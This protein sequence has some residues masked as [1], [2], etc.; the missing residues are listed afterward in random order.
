MDVLTEGK[1]VRIITRYV[2][3]EEPKDYVTAVVKLITCIRIVQKVVK[4]TQTIKDLKRRG[5][6]N[7]KAFPQTD[8]SAVQLC[9]IIEKSIPEIGKTSI[10]KAT[11]NNTAIHVLLDTGSP[12]SFI[13]HRLITK[14][15]L[16]V[17]KAPK[18]S[19]KGVVSEES[20]NTTEA[21]EVPL[22]IDN[23]TF[24][25][26][27]YV[28]EYI[29]H[30]VIIGYPTLQRFPELFDSVSTDVP[31]Y[32]IIS[33]EEVPRTI[34]KDIYWVNTVINTSTNSSFEKLPHWLAEKYKDT[35]RDDL[36][37][38]DKNSNP[39]V[40]HEIELIS[41][42]KTPKSQP[43]RVTPKVEEEINKIVTDL[44]DKQ[45]IIS[46]KS[47]FSSPIVM[48]KKKDGTYRLCVDYRTLNKATVKDPFPLPRT[49]S[50]LAK[51]GAASIFTTLDLHSGYHQIPMKREDRYKTAFVTP[52]GK[53]EYTVMPFGLVNA[54]STFSRY[55]AD[56]FREM[57][58]VNVYL[59][60]ILIFS[61]SETEH[62]KHIDLVLQ[63][64]KNEQLIV[65]KPK[66]S[67]A[68][69]EVEYLGYI[70]SEHKI[71]PV[72]SK[73]E[74]ISKF[75]TPNNVKAA[76]RFLGMINY[77]RRFIPHCSTIAKP[78]QDYINEESTWL[79]PQT[80][81]MNELKTILTNHPI[82]VPFQ[83]NGNYRLTT[84]ASKYGIGAVLEE[85]TPTGNVLGVVGYYSQSLK[86]AQQNYPAGELELLGIV[87]AL[88]HF[89]YLLHGIH[90]SLRTDHVSLLSLRNE[91]EP[92]P[93]VQRHL[94]KLADYDFELSYIPGPEN[95]VADALSRVGYNGDRPKEIVRSIAAIDGIVHI[96]PTTWFLDWCADPLAGAALEALGVN[97]DIDINSGDA[98]AFKKYRKKF[99]LSTKYSELFSFKND[100]LRYRE[101]VVVPKRRRFELLRVY[102]DHGIHGGHFGENVTFTKL[103]AEYFWPKMY[104][105]IKSHIK[106]CTHCQMMKAHRLKNQGLLTP[107]DV[108]KGR[109]ID[110]AMDF[111]TGLPPA[112]GGENMI[113]VVVDRFTKRAHFI[114]AQ[115]PLHSSDVLNLMFRY[116]FAYHGFPKTI[117]SDRD[118]RFTSNIYREFTERL[119]IKL[120]MSSSNHPQTDGQSERVIQI[121]NR[122]L[123]TYAFSDH[124]RWAW[125]LPQVEFVYNS[126]PNRTL[127]MSPFEADLG[128]V[129]NAPLLKTDG[130][131]DARHTGGVEWTRR[132]KAITMRIQDALT[133][134][135]AEMEVEQNRKRRPLIFEKGEFA[136][137]HRN[138]YFHA[139]K[140]KK[141]QPLFVGPF[142]VVK[143]IHDN[144]YELD[145]PT[146]VK[147]HRVINVHHLK[148]F[149]SRPDKYP[150]E[151]PIT[152]EEILERANEVTGLVG[153][154]EDKKTYYCTMEDVDPTISVPLTEEQYN[155]IP[156]WTRTSIWKNFKQLYLDEHPDEEGE[157]VVGK[158]GTK[159]SLSSATT[160]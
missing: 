26:Q 90:F 114:A 35:V 121:L 108:P 111:A 93:R 145:L 80:D 148:K 39:I 70:I 146:H 43:Y 125:L 136:L 150:K 91:T 118:V 107:L 54:P 102:H 7:T 105:D 24:T 66:C 99:K 11:T 72:Q 37:A 158:D 49:E 69:K 30:D 135:Q 3:K 16:E 101:Q 45:F 142:K 104:H 64:L 143:K 116:I 67:F 36:P 57:K 97:A 129:P 96:D 68:E 94:D 144:A 20:A 23:K 160:V 50:A 151:A 128:Y 33:T 40:F 38:R 58:F 159:A 55:M 119:G 79:Q 29:G 47:P 8:R 25:I 132:V 53:Y 9:P 100:V 110:I 2:M 62:W 86:G 154:S 141:I 127:G 41:G 81:A 147:T 12:T 137:V 126:T 140:Y 28:T 103:R 122:L 71:K 76:Q 123:R 89:K 6:T 4:P 31:V 157:D 84:D 5:L 1:L 152:E 153:I 112:F 109:W 85:V 130:E 88:D 21:V 113:M 52:S 60:D 133:E 156:L 13:N 74:A 22:K 18:F 63:K 115:T 98:S 120:T 17:Y 73:C 27:A 149:V 10:V 65:K 19:F 59:D 83:P 48:V 46:S 106:Y 78:I 14:L 138:A 131:L 124:R 44:I 139:G 95:V 134:A 117:T 56:L 77:Y 87:Q 155:K 34:N 92:A 75:P 51:I 15:D 82:L 42:M 32:S 61:S